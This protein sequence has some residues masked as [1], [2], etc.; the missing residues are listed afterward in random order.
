MILPLPMHQLS[1]TRFL[2]TA[3]LWL[4]CLI[5][6]TT[7]AAVPTPAPP[8][9]AASGY[10]LVDF[11]S[12]KVLAEKGAGNRLEPAS[13]TKIMTAYAVFREL[14]EG[15]INLEDSV[16]ISEKAWRTPGSR[17]FIEVGKKVKVINLV[18]GMI[19]QSGNDACVALAEH[20]A[21]SE[22]TFTELMN[23]IARELGMT[24]THFTNSTGL[25]D[26]DHYT[27]PADIAKVAAA[28]IRDFPEYYPWYSDKSFV[29]NDITQHN[30]NKLLWRDNSVDGIKTGHTEAAGYCLVAS[31]QR[32]SM[33]LISVV[34]GTKG[35]EARA[36]A[37]QSLLNYGFRFYETHQLYTAGEVLN[38]A[39]IWMGD[40]EK[41]PLGLSQDLNVTIPRHQYQNLDA[42][43]E[44]E[45]KIM[46]PV[47][48][49]E[50]LGHVSISLNGEPVTEAPLVAL[51][52]IADGNIW[53]LIKDSALL[54]LE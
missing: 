43:M 36:Q 50:V 18:K 51:K 11:H 45:P 5:T 23:N 53:Q 15:N 42:R 48:Q 52:S 1:P 28:T 34:M 41:L 40:K 47:K 54:W 20:I 14:K 7:Y 35:E 25:P 38:R 49:G 26:D 10:L 24:D 37:S 29:F 17:M 3:L 39:R 16:L 22:A 32:E 46:A 9:V 2:K 33:R 8:D 12:G 27:T 21:G 19:I 4:S 6:L 30:R 44:I 13:L 31:A